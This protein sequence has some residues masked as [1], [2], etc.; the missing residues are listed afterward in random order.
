MRNDIQTAVTV[1]GERKARLNVVGGEVRKVIEHLGNGHATTE[2]TENVCHGDAR[3]SDTRLAAAD[4]WIDRDA[5]AVVHALEIA[6]FFT[7]FNPREDAQ[8]R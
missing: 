6:T 5:L 3:A 7:P 1:C 2:I 4:A 8:E